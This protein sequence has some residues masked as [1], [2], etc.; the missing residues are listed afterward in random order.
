MNHFNVGVEGVGLAGEWQQRRTEKRH[1]SEFPAAFNLT[2]EKYC[3]SAFWWR[4]VIPGI[5][6][7]SC[8]GWSSGSPSLWGPH[9]QTV[10]GAKNRGSKKTFFFFLKY[11]PPPPPHTQTYLKGKSLK[12]LY[13][14]WRV[15]VIFIISWFTQSLQIKVKKIKHSEVNPVSVLHWCIREKLRP[16]CD[17]I[18]QWGQN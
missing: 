7:K 4:L 8:A 11:L 12:T 1:S 6:R 15:H 3:W 16:D 5:S 2:S 13:L 10:P 17:D 9:C 18:D 14:N